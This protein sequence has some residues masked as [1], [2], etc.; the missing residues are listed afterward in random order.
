MSTEFLNQQ[1]SLVE[2]ERQE[3]RRQYRDRF[4]NTPLD[5]RKA[6]GITWYPIDPGKVEIG[7]GD[8]LIVE[9]DKPETAENSG[10]FQTG[11][12]VTLWSNADPSA[13]RPPSVGGVVIRA[14]SDSLKLALDCEDEPDW[15]DEGKVGLDLSYDE[16]TYNEMDKALR[17]VLAAKGD[18]TALLRDVLLGQKAPENK[19]RHHD[20]VLPYL[21]ESQNEALNGI[22]RAEDLAIVH[23]PP[24]TGKTHTLIHAISHTLKSEKQVLVCAASNLAV[25]L[26]VEKLAAA[27]IN[28]VRVG[29]PARISNAV[30][31]N[32]LDVRVAIHRQHKDIKSLRKDAEKSRREALKFKRNFSREKRELRKTLLREARDLQKEARR[33]ERFILKDVI[34]KAQVVACTLATAGGSIME[35][36][37]FSSLFIDEAAQALGPSCWIPILKADRVI[38]AGD[39]CQLPP[40]VKSRAAEKGGLSVSLFE[41][42]I[43]HQPEQA[44]M[45]RTQYRMHE[46]IMEFSNR[47]F[48]HHD[49]VAA[50]SVANQK[51]EL[52]KESQMAGKAFHFVD[53]AGC[54]Y[55][56]ELNPESKSTSNPGEAGLLL[57]HLGAFLGEFKKPPKL[58]EGS[59]PEPDSSRPASI[60]IISPYK[61]Q[62]KLLRKLVK[63]EKALWPWLKRINVD[64][65]DGFQGQERDVIYISMVRSNERGVIGFLGDTRRMNVALTRA[66]FNLVVIGDSA[67]LGN[68]GF[69]KDFLDYVDETGAY[70]SGWEFM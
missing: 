3:E 39:H 23:G 11:S 29:H 14:K 7:L 22:A 49:L 43:A 40:T 46:Q 61:D 63:E 31:Q 64:T 19:Q 70:A 8:R 18:R 33:L 36:R 10:I 58:E 38:F 50:E 44:V 62:V 60:G 27:G 5:V 54:G 30:L 26:L 48:Y 66:R 57:R 41:T 15:L 4:L 9:I 20:I 25:D 21:N 16:R 2:E 53:T 24:G 34:D 55:D 65:V 17:A 45:L 52:L 35:G 37:H 51:F 1:I 13:K 56:E 68:H 12:V 6:K 67:T 28:V 69:Y 59:F 47:K 42:A 32:S